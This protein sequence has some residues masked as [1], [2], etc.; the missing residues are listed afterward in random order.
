VKLLI[1]I[2]VSD[3][4]ATIYTQSLISILIGPLSERIIDKNW[5]SR[6][7]AYEDIV[8]E[9]NNGNTAIF[10]EYESHIVKILADSNASALD[11]GLDAV[12]V[13]IDKTPNASGIA[14]IHSLTRLLT[15]S[16]TLIYR[17]PKLP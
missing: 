15:Y 4:I 13:F 8:K 11:T 17:R 5:K 14:P 2:H 12:L 9:I 1:L 16:L 3:T 6:A 7:S 10:G